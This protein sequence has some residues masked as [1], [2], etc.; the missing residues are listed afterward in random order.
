[1]NNMTRFQIVIGAIIV[2][3][4]AL[5]YFAWLDHSRSLALSEKLNR[6]IN[7]L[8]AKLASTSL[9][10]A[11]NISSSQSALSEEI[12]KQKNSVGSI[13]QSLGAYSQQVNSYTSTVS[14]LQKLSK[15]DP[16]LLS[17]YSKVF[18]LS[19]NY[20]PERL[21]EIP[22][23]Y[24]YSDEKILKFHALAWPFLQKMIDA[25]TKDNVTLYVESAYRSFDEQQKLKGGYRVVY[26]AGTANSF[27]ADQGYSEHQ[28]GTAADLIT[29]GLGGEL[30]GFGDTKA[31]VWLLANAYK[32]GFILSYPENNKFYV[33]EPWHWRFVGVKLATD[34]HNKKKDFYDLDQRD[35]DEYLV[36]I[37]D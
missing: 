8:N 10:L 34:L 9:E 35:I 6:Q 21:A 16:Q 23:K 22:N 13:Q 26:G 36:S 7:E 37:F 17:K 1:M 4:L 24:A 31:Y 18:F 20:A 2:L 32:Y 30:D 28:L 3:A 15:T 5:G 33:F 11:Q 29:S 14:N 19:E 12:N 27:S 25:A